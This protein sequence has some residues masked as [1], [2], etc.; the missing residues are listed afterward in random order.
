MSIV[1][2]SKKRLISLSDGMLT[3]T[4]MTTNYGSGAGSGY[5]GF[6]VDSP[7]PVLVLHSEV[8]CKEAHT[9]YKGV[10][11]AGSAL[12]SA[13]YFPV[14][15]KQPIAPT[16]NCVVG[17]SVTMSSIGEHRPSFAQAARSSTVGPAVQSRLP[18]IGKPGLDMCLV[19]ANTPTLF[20]IFNGFST[21]DATRQIYGIMEF[22]Q[23]D[24]DYTEIMRG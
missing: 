9:S 18:N 5:F 23:G 24:F 3:L 11:V 12:G 16:A 19:P 21:V 2:R 8:W 7:T 15:G 20:G 14:L 17:G 22:I 10:A 6:I 4:T 13:I 1:D